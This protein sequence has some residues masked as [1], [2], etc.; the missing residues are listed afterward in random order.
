M[1]HFS[2][3]IWY[4]F[5]LL[6]TCKG[7]LKGLTAYVS[8][9]NSDGTTAFSSDYSLSLG[10]DSTVSVCSLRPSE[11]ASSELYYVKLVLK[12]AAGKVLADNFY[13]EG[14][15]EG[16]W[17]A[18]QKIAKP[19][20][21][22]SYKFLKDGLVSITVENK[23]AAPEPMVRLKLSDRKTGEQILPA[24]YEDNYFA[25]QGGEKKTL[26]VKYLSE[27]E[28]EPVVTLEQLR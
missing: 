25:L 14:R 1:V 4:T 18:I 13:W 17:T 19:K 9:L 24:F 10:D 2:T 11:M 6:H 5:Q 15:E 20:L 3:R 27:R 28:Y 23:S 8:V 16:N 7:D 22:L 26:T 21:K 12:D